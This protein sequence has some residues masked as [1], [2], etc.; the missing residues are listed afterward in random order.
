LLDDLYVHHVSVGLVP[1][2]LSGLL[3]FGLGILAAGV[4]ILRA[5]RAN[6]LESLKAE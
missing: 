3:V 1:V 6:P 2:L 4:S 5:A